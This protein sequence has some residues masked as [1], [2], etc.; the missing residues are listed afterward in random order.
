[1]RLPI[2]PH[3]HKRFT[4]SLHFIQAFLVGVKWHLI[5][6]L[7]CIS[8]MT[9]D[10][11]YLFMCILSVCLHFLEN[12]LFTSF[13][14]FLN[15]L[16]FYCWVVRGFVYP[17]K[18]YILRYMICKYYLLF[19]RLSFHIM[20]CILCSTRVFT[21]YKVPFIN[22][23]VPC[24]LISYLRNHRLIPGH[25]DLH[26]CILLKV[27]NVLTLPFNFCM[28]FDIRIQ[29]HSLAGKYPAIPVILEI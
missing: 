25:K 5:M 3:P 18:K 14:H 2:L 20:N 9:N 10:N 22:F 28:W 1:M 17:G 15:G 23:L 21:F 29:L 7:I 6:V 16:V 12:C 4:T 24:V 26:I 19:L 27:F 8:I 13:A 11:E